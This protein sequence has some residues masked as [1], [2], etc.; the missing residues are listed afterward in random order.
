MLRLSKVQWLTTE[1]LIIYTVGIIGIAI[2]IHKDFVLLTP[3]NLFVSSL[4]M[5]WNHS[6]FSL[7]NISVLLF[8]SVFGFLAEAHGTNYGI[9][10]GDYRYGNILGWRLWQTPLAAGLLWLIVTYGAGVFLNTFFPK[11]HFLLKATLGAL[12]LV[13][14]DTF[15]EPVA[16]HLGFWS[17]AGNIVPLQNY[18][19]WYVIA[20]IQLAV[21][22]YFLPNEKNKIG[23]VLLLLQFI[24]FIS[25]RLLIQK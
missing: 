17:W 2:P 15:I 20:W 18:I 23:I 16:I 7:K 9:I 11:I 25:I 4:I 14:L 24:F 10:F 1:L 21:F 22:S 3:L 5:L 6:S 19:G 8:V 13:S 12:L